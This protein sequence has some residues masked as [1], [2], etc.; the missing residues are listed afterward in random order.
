[1]RRK[2][3]LPLNASYTVFFPTPTI[4]VI[5]F[6]SSVTAQGLLEDYFSVDDYLLEEYFIS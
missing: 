5:K 3:N 6:K 2:L 4:K 1:M